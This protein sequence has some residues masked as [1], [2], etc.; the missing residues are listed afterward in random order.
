[1][2]ADDPGARRRGRG[3]R[4][5]CRRDAAVDVAGGAGADVAGDAGQGAGALP[6]PVAENLC[7]RLLDLLGVVPL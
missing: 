2:P 3:R 4:P 5:R 7:F 6:G 1:M